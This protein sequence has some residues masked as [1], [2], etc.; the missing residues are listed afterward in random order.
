MP[1]SLFLRP[2]HFFTKSRLSL[3]VVPSI[4]GNHILLLGNCKSIGRS[5]A[6]GFTTTGTAQHWIAHSTQDTQAKAGTEHVEGEPTPVATNRGTNWWQG[7]IFG[8]K[9]CIGIMTNQ[10]VHAIRSTRSL[11]GASRADDVLGHHL[12]LTFCIDKKGWFGS[13]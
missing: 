1:R 5:L 10:L 13:R 7:S 4:F 9:P 12:G 8:E 11:L 2:F 6:F 3:H